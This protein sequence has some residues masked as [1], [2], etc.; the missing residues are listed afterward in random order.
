MVLSCLKQFIDTICLLLQCLISQV[1]VKLLIRNF[2]GLLAH[3]QT[4]MFIFLNVKPFEDLAS[5]QFRIISTLVYRSVC[6]VLLKYLI[7]RTAHQENSILSMN[8]L[9]AN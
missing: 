8:G 4:F 1:C 6:S 7:W 9:P 3:K 2:H 5:A